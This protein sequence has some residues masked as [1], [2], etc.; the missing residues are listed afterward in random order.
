[1]PI[2]AGPGYGIILNDN[3]MTFVL[4]QFCTSLF[5]VIL[6]NAEKNRFYK[7]LYFFIKAYNFIRFAV[8]I[9]Y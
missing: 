7:A 8:E 4:T 6:R 3:M 5:W 2:A 9:P 1:M